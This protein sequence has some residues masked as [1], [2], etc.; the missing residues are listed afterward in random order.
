MRNA[1][2]PNSLRFRLL[3]S[4]A[5]L[6]AIVLPITAFA[7][8]SY[9]RIAVEQT[10]DQRLEVHLDN[11]VVLSLR[12]TR[13]DESR[14]AEIIVAEVKDEPAV[15]VEEKMAQRKEIELGDPLFKRPFSGWY[16]QIRALDSPLS[17]TVISDSLLDHRLTALP[18]P[19]APQSGE[20][21]KH[22]YISGPEGQLLRAVE[23]LIIAGGEVAGEKAERYTYMVAI[24]SSQLDGQVSQFRNMLF[25][26]LGVLGLG[27][28]LA[29]VIQVRYV[30]APLSIISRKLNDI[31]A[32]K[33]DH[34]RGEFPAE[35]EPLQVELNALIRS[36]KDIV[37]RAR[38]HVGNLAHALKTPL[39]VLA[40][41]IDKAREDE[42]AAREFADIIDKQTKVMNDQVR[43][44][45]DRAR[46]AAQISVIGSSTSVQPVTRSLSR[47]LQKIYRKKNIDLFC[48]CGDGLLFRGEQQDLEEMLGNLLDNAFK[49]A[50]GQVHLSI[51]KAPDKPGYLTINVE[52]DGPGLTA[53]KRTRA[54]K[55]GQRLDENLPGSGLGLSIVADLAHLYNGVFLLEVSKM[56]GLRA[57]LQLPVA[58]G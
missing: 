23:R 45:L 35:I 7:L 54:M 36:N 57:K 15:P 58:I 38:T 9:Y 5:L 8:T 37:E 29:G 40:N 46:M 12:R 33:A 24:S 48:E 19:T 25:L 56:G 3:A 50:R 11:L 22:G 32:G 51:V 16:W 39:S 4:T 13:D 44:H 26:A 53:D 10:F 52:D 34:L 30:L 43:H 31:R 55:R 21:L 14:E 28:I 20:K 2:R 18:E 6:V 17:N 1:L 42:G 49:W 41:E 27:L 47:T